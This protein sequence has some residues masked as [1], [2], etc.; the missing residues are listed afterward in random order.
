M[1]PRP[2]RDFIVDPSRHAR[3]AALLQRLP[4]APLMYPLAIIDEHITCPAA[5]MRHGDSFL[6]HLSAPT[7]HVLW[8]YMLT[9]VAAENLQALRTGE[10][11]TSG[12]LVGTIDAYFIPPALIFRA[13]VRAELFCL[14]SSKWRGSDRATVDNPAAAIRQPMIS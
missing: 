11:S 13:H 7:G 2:F 6:G 12:T 9:F 1:P 4:R 8:G 5:E 3:R 10:L 14:I